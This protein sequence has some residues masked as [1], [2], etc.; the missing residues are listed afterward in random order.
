MKRAISAW[1]LTTCLTAAVTASAAGQTAPQIRFPGADQPGAGP[2][3]PAPAAGEWSE[4]RSPMR[5]LPAPGA[6]ES[7]RDSIADQLNRAELARI[8]HG[9]RS[10][11]R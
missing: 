8:L 2:A 6:G 5:A 3:Q 11:A 7:G 10:R 1:L 9:R 4:P